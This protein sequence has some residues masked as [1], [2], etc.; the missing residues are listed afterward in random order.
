MTTAV[1]HLRVRWAVLLTCAC[2]V[3]LA[4]A[5]CLAA[6]RGYLVQ[7]DAQDR[8][9]G[10]AL[11]T[12]PDLEERVWFH[13][14][15]NWVARSHDI[16]L[17]S[18]S[19]ASKLKNTEPEYRVAHID[20]SLARV[21]S[22]GRTT[23]EGRAFML[24][25]AEPLRLRL[26]IWRQVFNDFSWYL[27]GIFWAA[28]SAVLVTS[29]AWGHVQRAM[30]GLLAG[31]SATGHP[32]AELVHVLKAVRSDQE[33]QAVWVEQ[34]TRFVADAAHQLRTPMAV[35]RA[36]IQTVISGHPDGQQILQEMLES[37]DRT[38][39]VTNQLLSL[40]RLDQMRRTSGFASLSLKS[41]VTEALNAVAPLLADKHLDFEF[42]GE[43]FHVGGDE[44]ML[45]EILRN[46]LAN[47]IHHSPEDGR[48]GVLLRHHSDC[49]ELIVWDEGAGIDDAVRPRLFTPY[50]SKGGVGL[51]LSICQQ[52]AQAMGATVGLFD[53]IDVAKRIGV[54]AVI[55][56]PTH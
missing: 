53:R 6:A 15:G 4:L 23:P 40:N 29:H 54:D 36:Q 20:G 44:T 35:L 27:A 12:L 21:A 16:P 48:I 11:K 24:Q 38:V 41:A 26:P 5:L 17:T 8:R 22:V 9:L 49:R 14:G 7:A 37:V 3:G 51:G 1:V 10:A 28:V 50:A 39:A 55:R 18:I 56:W 43:D 47:A 19:A 34:Q 32:P 46:L 52:L 31:A 42:Q 13:N 2:A 45:V 33:E 25:V 30:A